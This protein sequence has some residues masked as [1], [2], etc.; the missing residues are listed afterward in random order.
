MQIPMRFVAIDLE[1]T[2]L[3][4]MKDTIIEVA[5]ILF[6]IEK[7]EDG[8]I[9][10][11]IQGERS[12]LVN[13]GRE[14]SE[15]VSLITGITNSMV[16]GKPTWNDIQGRVSQFLEDAIIV[17]HNVLFDISMLETHG[18]QLK[19]RVILDTFE[20][21]EIFSQ[22]SESLNL[23]F[24]AKRYGLS[25]GEAEHRALGD[26]RLSIGLLEQYL[27]DGKKLND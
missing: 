9:K 10:I 4:P 7:K 19:E 24:L 20:L 11:S 6:D 1:T 21:S 12:M 3:D 17:G 8:Q 23:G 16:L 22:D 25:A 15:E 18:I 5:A 27:N 13:P 14:I 2:G 26:T